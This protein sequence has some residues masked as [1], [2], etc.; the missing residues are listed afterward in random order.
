MTLIGVCSAC[1]LAAPL[2]DWGEEARL[3]QRGE[4][5]GREAIMARSRGMGYA[6]TA[7]ACAQRHALLRR[8]VP[9]SVPR[10]STAHAF[11]AWPCSSCPGV[12]VEPLRT[13]G[14]IQEYVG[15]TLFKNNT[16]AG[17]AWLFQLNPLRRAGDSAT[18][19]FGSFRHRK[20]VPALQPE[21]A[22]ARAW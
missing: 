4:D 1:V 10:L 13:S 8:Q 19:L 22:V 21:P 7:A 3:K 12:L 16:G 14:H 20:P 15:L 18:T 6:I 9:S 5:V 2:G 17:Q 11:R